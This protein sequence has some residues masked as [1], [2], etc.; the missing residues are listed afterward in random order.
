MIFL[1]DV[2]LLLALFDPSHLSHET[3]HRWFGV[4]KRAW[5]SCPVTEAGFVR[6]AS[7]PKYPGRI[8]SADEVLERLEIFRKGTDHRFWA[9][10]FSLADSAR[11][12]LDGSIAP[13]HLTDLYLLALAVRHGGKLATFDARIPVR[14]VPKGKAALEM[15][16][17]PNPTD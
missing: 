9:E 6:V 1:F 16:L 5:A 10:G 12:R 11:V 17:M 7:Q 15:I 4:E 13:N 14:A 2:N 8:G 3:A